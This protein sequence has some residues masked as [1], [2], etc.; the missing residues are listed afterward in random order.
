MISAALRRL[1]ESLP[2]DNL[3]AKPLNHC[4]SSLLG[5]HAVSEVQPAAGKFGSLSLWLAPGCCGAMAGN[6]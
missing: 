5:F 4:S 3:E 1:A 2:R 6:E